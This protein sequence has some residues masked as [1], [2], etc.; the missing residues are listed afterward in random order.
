MRF[1]KLRIAWS[2]GWG[3]LAVLVISL[4]VR[5]SAWDDHFGYCYASARELTFRSM[6]GRMQIDWGYNPF[7]EA[8]AGEWLFDSLNI[9]DIYGADHPEVARSA[10]GFNINSKF[11][12]IAVPHWPAFVVTVAVGAFPWIRWRRRFSLRTLLIAT[13]LVAAVLG[14]IAY[15][16]R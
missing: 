13:T 4:W 14:L 16:A 6:N 7:N 12:F 11:I 8:D 3:L 15:A 10:W 1:H 2:V 9:D 5:S